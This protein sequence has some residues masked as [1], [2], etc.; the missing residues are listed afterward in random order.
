MQVA[1]DPGALRVRF[2]NAEEFAASRDAWQRLV[3]D[4]DVDPLF[5][6]WDWQHCWWTHHAAYLGAKLHLLGLYTEGGELVGIAPFYAHE[7]LHRGLRIR[8]MELLGLAWRDDATAF[9]EYL[10]VIARRGYADAVLACVARWLRSEPHWHD[11][12]LPYLKPGSLA[13][14]LAREHLTG[15]AEVRE[16]DE[17]AGYNVNLPA[18]FAEY[19]RR[20]K[21]GVRRKLLH[22]R[23]KLGEIGVVQVAAH[24]VGGTLGLLRELG[25]QRWGDKGERLHRF[26]MDFAAWQAEAGGLRLTKLTSAGRTL[27]IMY[28][29]RIGNTEYYLQSAFD[30]AAS[31]GLS[32]GYQH[33]GYVL[34]RACQEG[35]VRFDFLAG[36]GR[37]RDYKRDLAQ[38]CSTLVCCHVIRSGWLRALYRAHGLLGRWRAAMAGSARPAAGEAMSGDCRDPCR[39]IVSQFAAGE[40]GET[41][42]FR[43]SKPGDPPSPPSLAPERGP[44]Q[45]TWFC[46]G[47]AP[48]G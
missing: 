29:V 23:G 25:A 5:M 27:S 15:I 6:S 34:E 30:P 10:D 35:I 32:L 16:V 41:R 43:Q 40:A 28:D 7:V 44:D 46:A 48:A 3:A 42:Q 9:S 1:A 38:E 21:S 47:S 13:L 20:L 26:N 36:K 37:H 8:R 22:Q 2:W 12:A 11:L 18:S 4:A 31:H 33:I 24:E 39:R 14:R 45:E 19:T 17:L